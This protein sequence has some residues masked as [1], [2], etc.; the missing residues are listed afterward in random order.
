MGLAIPHESLHDFFLAVL[1]RT[2]VFTLEI[3][4][5]GSSTDWRPVNKACIF[6]WIIV[7]IHH[8]K[9]FISTPRHALDQA[10]KW[11]TTS[12]IMRLCARD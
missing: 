7:A 8:V 5:L 11:E 10:T 3:S 9:T 6:P 1:F 2:L 4:A 12:D